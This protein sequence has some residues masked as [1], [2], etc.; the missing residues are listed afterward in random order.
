MDKI[1]LGK[2]LNLHAAF[3][4]GKEWAPLDFS[5][6]E[7]RLF[8]S[9]H[10]SGVSVQL[11]LKDDADGLCYRLSFDA[12]WPTR[13]RLS[14]TAE[15][16][17]DVFHLIPANIHG[18]NNLAHAE[19]GHYPN[20]TNEPHESPFSSPVWEFRA[21]RAPYPISALC[22]E[23]EVVA[24]SVDPYSPTD[25]RRDGFVANG[26]YAELPSTCGISLGYGNVPVT[27]INK[28]NSSA[29]TCHRVRT[30]SC[31]GH[32]YRLAG[33]RRA[34]HEI[35]RKEYELR[36]ESAQHACPVR[37]AAQALC[38][39]FVEVNWSPEMNAYSNMTLNL[40]GHTFLRSW[41]PLIE[42]GWTGGGPLAY[43]F[44]RAERQLNLND[45]Y[46]EKAA[47]GRELLD[48][49]ATA[50]NPDSGLLYDLTRPWIIGDPPGNHVN[51]W[52]TYYPLCKNVHGAYTNGSAVYYLLKS[53]LEL[54]SRSEEV[55]GTWLVAALGTLDTVIQLQREDGNFGFSYAL[56]NPEVVDWEG[57]AG[58]WFAAAAVLAWQWSGEERYLDAA[59][60]A[61]GYYHGF[62]K[63]LNCWGTPMDT[64]KSVDEEG[65]L[66]FIKAARHLYEA[67]GEK[68]FLDAAVDG[69]NYELLWRYGYRT[70]PP[71]PP[72]NNGAWNACG[73][74]L[75]SVSNP[76]AHPMGLIVTG[77]LLWLA[78]ETGDTYWKQRAED[79]VRWVIQC[80][81]LYPQTSGYG[82]FGVLT[83][84]FCPSDGLL[85]ER[86]DDGTPS[87]MWFTYNGWAAAAALEGIL[88]WLDM[89]GENNA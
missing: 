4:F 13:L 38:D 82:R 83:E 33:D 57:F 68:E 56:N 34:A 39:A 72:L 50:R 27:F 81:E 36:G 3:L 37:D 43:P 12:P 64:W 65:N 25:E 86:F 9:R 52:W 85:E 74:S 22:L 66:A 7:D 59:R 61:L 30:A 60:K 55:P 44:I 29:P 18:D 20:L 71:A 10:E 1:P 49:I 53:V 15:G 14:L 11:A 63:Q 47:S 77:D 48:R 32:I 28:E 76:H 31:S 2:G 78:K 84:R 40:D 26:L 23:N 16:Q 87:S 6:S 62:V 19:P 73:G 79:G 80:M 69:A 89:E 8:S 54:R 51:G 5:E 21:D 45:G 58:C 35:F 70:R 42:I 24:I 67:T 75:T 41:R 46:F 17:K 88:D